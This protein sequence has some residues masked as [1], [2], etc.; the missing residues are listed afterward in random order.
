V[1]LIVSIPAFG[2]GMA[3]NGNSSVT[4]VMGCFPCFG[5]SELTKV[6]NFTKATMADNYEEI[7]PF[8]KA[9]PDDISEFST[10]AIPASIPAADDSGTQYLLFEI[11]W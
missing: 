4:G 9:G 6:D 8:A 11:E 10:S 1:V 2:A 5:G 7:Q 3:P